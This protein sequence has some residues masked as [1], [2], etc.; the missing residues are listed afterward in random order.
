M[1]LQNLVAS[2]ADIVA[3]VADDQHLARGDTADSLAIVW[4]AENNN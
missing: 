3:L 4:V 1:R 2:L